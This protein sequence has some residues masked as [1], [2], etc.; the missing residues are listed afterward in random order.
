M[1]APL[2]VPDVPVGFPLLAVARGQITRPE[3]PTVPETEAGGQTTSPGGRTTLG[4][5]V[6]GQ[7]TPRREARGP[8]ARPYATPSS[9]ASPTLA[10]PR[11]VP[12]TL[13]MPYVA[14]STPPARRT[15]SASTTLAVPPVALTSQLYLL[16]YLC[17]PQAVR[18]PLALP[19]HQQSSPAKVVPVAPPVNP[20]SMTTREKWGFRLPVNTLTLSATSA[21]TLS[22]VPS[23]VYATIVDP[24]SSR[25]MEKDFAALIT[26]DT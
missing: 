2:S 21:S 10:A 3:G 22:L 14:P 24:K 8:T 1:P 12:M 26:N 23:S 5:G 25:T 18:E 9:P 15:A 4:I 16:Y 11:A 17:H 6:G 19:L 7:T 20:H 13:A